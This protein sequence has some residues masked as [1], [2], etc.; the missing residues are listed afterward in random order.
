MP[1]FLVQYDRSKGR[2]VTLQTFD[3][4]ERRR[5]DDVRLELE[6]RLKR[7]KLEHEVVLL[8]A[9]TEDALRTTHRRYFEELADL[10]TH[11]GTNP[12]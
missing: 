6:I 8:E 3:D 2:L 11:P 4:S 1:V 7:Q 5:A 10:A 9:T 12:E